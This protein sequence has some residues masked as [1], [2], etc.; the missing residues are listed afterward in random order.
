MGERVLHQ[1]HALEGGP[2]GLGHRRRRRSVALRGAGA[3]LAV[4]G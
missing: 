2:I 4:K 3:G 1:P